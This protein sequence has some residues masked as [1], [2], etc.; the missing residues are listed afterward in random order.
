MVD[1]FSL[2]PDSDSMSLVIIISAV[3]MVFAIGILVFALLKSFYEWD[4]NN[5]SP[6]LTVPATVIAKRS[7]TGIDESGCYHYITFQ[8]ENG[9]AFE[10]CVSYQKYD[11]LAEGDTGKLTFQG[12]RYI[13]FTR[14]Y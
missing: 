14:D 12:T 6:C 1:F 10:F 4:K 3:L 13:S 2:D 8:C 7:C 11:K 9:E 5:H